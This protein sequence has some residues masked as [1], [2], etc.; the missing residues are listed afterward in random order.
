[1]VIKSI[2]SVFMVLSISLI[3]I[4]AEDYTKYNLGSGSLKSNWLLGKKE[5]F[6]YMVPVET[7][8]VTL[9]HDDKG[10]TGISIGSGNGK[11]TVSWTKGAPKAKVHAWVNGKW[12]GTNKISW[13]CWA[14]VRKDSKPP[15][16]KPPTIK[17]PREPVYK[18]R[19]TY[20]PPRF[21]PNRDYQYQIP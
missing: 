17:P 10:S 21:D 2:V 19:P 11:A 20:K 7:E 12:K 4:K 1:M 5:D 3:L 6:Y 14:W 13:T 16:S 9:D 15:T 18:P 8:F